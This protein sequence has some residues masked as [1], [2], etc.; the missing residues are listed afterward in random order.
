MTK[1]T[2]NFFTHRGLR[3]SYLDSA[4]GESD[5]Q[6]VLL[7][8]GFPDQASMW[9]PQIA[10]L[11][12]A[13]M[14]CIAPD[15]VGCGH[16]Q[17]AP[18]QRDYKA[19][20]I[21]SD[22]IALLD[23]L[24]IDEVDVIGHDWGAV[25]AWFFAAYYPE[26]S[27]RLVPISVGHPNA[28]AR[29]GWQQKLAGWYTLYFQLS[30]IADHLLKGHSRLSLRRIFGSHPEMEE[31]MNRLAEPGRLRAAVRIYRANL[32]EVLSRSQPAVKA[33]TLGIWSTEDPFLTEQQM[34]DSQRWVS[35]E[36]AYK[37]LSGGHWIGLEQS[38]QVN[39][40]LLAYLR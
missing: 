3:L 33:P 40:I 8:H 10:A 37:R 23:Q 22:H 6:V 28:Y 4:P 24:G 34:L 29:A 9:E 7:L 27:R 12:A 15:T 19:R 13:G 1:V 17:M 26:R 2:R 14:R 36:W 16:S 30:P 5:R 38:D 11:H 20:A 18:R 21:A 31:V 39:E 25:I 35:G 32:L